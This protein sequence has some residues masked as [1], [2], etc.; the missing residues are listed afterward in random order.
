MAMTTG[1]IGM[2]D[3]RVSAL[4]AMAPQ[5]YW[6]QWNTSCD[7]WAKALIAWREGQAAGKACTQALRVCANG[8]NPVSVGCDQVCPEDVGGPIATETATAAVTTNCLA[9]VGPVCV[10]VPLLLVAA[11]AAYLIWGRS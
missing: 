10:S 3:S 4:C 7:A 5:S 2:G 1:M 9:Q 8:A 11:A 6:S